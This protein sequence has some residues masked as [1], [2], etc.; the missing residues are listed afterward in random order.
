MRVS[1][2]VVDVVEDD[3]LIAVLIRRQVNPEGAGISRN[4][5][6]ARPKGTAEF[7]ALANAGW[8]DQ[9]DTPQVPVCECR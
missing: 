1:V 2:Q 6:G 3:R 7:G 4:P 5:A 8:A 9:D